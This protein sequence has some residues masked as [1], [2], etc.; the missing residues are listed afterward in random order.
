MGYC[1][2]HVL[3]RLHL[4]YVEK[5][6]EP[7]KLY[8]KIYQGFRFGKYAAVAAWLGMTWNAGMWLMD[9]MKRLNVYDYN[10]KR[11]KFNNDVEKTKKMWNYCQ[12]RFEEMER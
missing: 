2:T 11:M 9:E 5:R 12:T 8:F 3:W 7:T 1:V 4:K 10:T 6:R